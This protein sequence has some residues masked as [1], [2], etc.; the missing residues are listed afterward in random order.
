MTIF[1]KKT[2]VGLAEELKSSPNFIE[3]RSKVFGGRK[4]YIDN[5]NYQIWQRGTSFTGAYDVTADRFFSADMNGTATI[6]RQSFYNDDTQ[7][8]T[9]NSFYYYRHNQTTAATDY[10]PNFQHRVYNILA[11]AGKTMT[12]SFWAKANKPIYVRGY[13][14]QSYGPAQGGSVYYSSRIGDLTKRWRKY[15]ITFVV[16]D[17]NGVT[18]NVNPENSYNGIYL[19]FPTNTTFSVDI[20]DVQ[21]EEGTRATEFEY[22]TYKQE[23][24]ECQRYY[25][26]VTMADNYNV[27]GNQW[28]STQCDGRVVFPV[29]M[30]TDTPTITID[31]VDVYLENTAGGSGWSTNV[32]AVANRTSRFG[33][34]A[35]CNHNGNVGAAVQVQYAIQ[36]DTE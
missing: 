29:E 33:F 25:Y 18:I 30:R 22:R 26:R 31:Q 20:A 1:S 36:A 8:Y 3:H 9:G 32:T 35:R 28:S 34:G 11:T 21:L 24:E 7:D 2:E 19:Q 23:L 13:F 12:L 16:P 6:S 5:G 15:S 27:T 10:N 4:N 14:Y 17:V